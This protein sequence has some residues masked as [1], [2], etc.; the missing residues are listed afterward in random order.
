[1]S[2]ILL[3]PE[4]ERGAA[5]YAPSTSNAVGVLSWLKRMALLERTVIGN[6]QKIRKAS[7]PIVVGFQLWV[8]SV[9]LIKFGAV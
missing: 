5:P 8:F 2:P 3:D 4:R 9:A 1:M 7:V 6:S